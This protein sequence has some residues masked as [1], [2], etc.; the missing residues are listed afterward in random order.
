MSSDLSVAGA[1]SAKSE[2]Q[3]YTWN[4]YRCAYNVYANEQTNWDCTPILLL[5][6]IGVGL[7]RQFWDRFAH[8]WLD[9]NQTVPLYNPDLLGCGDSETPRVAYYPDDW[10]AQLQGFIEQ[11]IQRPVIVISQGALFPVAIALTQRQADAEL[12]KGLILAGPPAWT[13]MTD[14]SPTWQNR[15]LWSLFDSPLGKAFYRY[16]RRE[17]FLQSFSA[18]QLFDAEADVDQNWLDMLRAGAADVE[19]RHAVF[20]FLAGF[21]RQ[22]YGETI[23]Q[24]QQPTLVLFGETAS[25]ISRSGKG[26]TAQE[27]LE[28]YLHHLPQGEGRIIAGRNVL[29]YERPFE[30]VN[31]IAPFVHKLAT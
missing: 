24:I 19:T 30:F 2:T 25:S 4:G 16:A 3:F 13:V 20:S 28:K 29:P 17:T 23:A 22:D 9:S 14:A 7:S 18:K 12:V 10:A 26:V 1:R 5:H 27:R 6:P 11:V 21:W 15:L 8:T 31:A